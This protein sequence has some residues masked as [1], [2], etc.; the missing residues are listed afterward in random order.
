VA[1]Q[2]YIGAIFL[3]A[4]NFA[5]RGYQLCAGQLL[6]IQQ[7]AA[8]FSILGTSYGGN[9]TTTFGLPDLRGR[10]AVGQGQGP[11]LTDIVLGEVAG[12][13]T[14]SVLTSNMPAHNHLVNVVSGAGNQSVPTNNFP[15]ALGVAHPVPDFPTTTAYAS[16]GANATM[17]PT[18]LSMTGSGIPLQIRNPYLG[19][20]YIIAITGLYPSRS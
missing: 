19:L 4:G 6:A 3:F 14:V 2:P 15:A 13:E 5:P 20:N 9:G 12:T 18:T 7:Y 11:G 17:A 1:S 8:L 10:G 16:S